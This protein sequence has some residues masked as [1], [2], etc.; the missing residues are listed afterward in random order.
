MG[1]FREVVFQD[2]NSAFK[3]IDGTGSGVSGGVT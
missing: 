3:H 1:Q 2:F